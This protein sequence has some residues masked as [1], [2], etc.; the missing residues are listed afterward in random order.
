MVVMHFFN[1]L[2]L[3]VHAKLVS[4]LIVPFIASPRMRSWE[5][6]APVVELMRRR[7]HARL[8]AFRSARGAV[9]RSQS[10]GH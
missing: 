8:H 10:L 1:E 4:E 2:G 6:V 9:A 3:L 5:R 7:Y